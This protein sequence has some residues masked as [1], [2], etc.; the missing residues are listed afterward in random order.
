LYLG[1][2]RSANFIAKRSEY[3]QKPVNNITVP[4]YGGRKSDSW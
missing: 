4:P 1:E 2:Y 3:K